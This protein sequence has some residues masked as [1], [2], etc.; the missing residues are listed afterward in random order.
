MA[1]SIFP[2]DAYQS[3]EVRKVAPVPSRPLADCGFLLTLCGGIP[4]GHWSIES[5]LLPFLM[6]CIS[7]FKP[8]VSFSVRRQ[9]TIAEE[10]ESLRAFKT[11]L[12]KTI[13]GLVF[14][15]KNVQWSAAY[16]IVTPQV[17]RL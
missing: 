5:M 14:F 12:T 4:R 3:I 9:I 2:A 7:P 1:A 16:A 15:L 17:E 8:A 13:F 11:E 10:K 6:K